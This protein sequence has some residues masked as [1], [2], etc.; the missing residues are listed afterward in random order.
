M[1]KYQFLPHMADV[2]L[3]VTASDFLELLRG[4]LEG[5]NALIKKDAC[6][7]NESPRE[8]IKKI[9]LPAQEKSLM[10]IDF[11]NEVL[12][13][14]QIHHAIFCRPQFKTLKNRTLTIQIWGKKVSGFDEDIKAVT[15]HD[16]NI[17]KNKQGLLETLVVFDI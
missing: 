7:T 10:L 11:L 1:R 15:Y 13:L 5:M 8:V 3:K 4:A 9:N 12:T 6:K 14:S 17:I 2:K 16:L